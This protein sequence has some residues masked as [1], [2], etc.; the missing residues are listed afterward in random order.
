MHALNCHML[1]AHVPRNA[2]ITYNHIFGT[3]KEQMGAVVHFTALLEAREHLLAN[4]GS[5]IPDQASAL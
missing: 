2:N 1:E 5:T 3:V 4:R